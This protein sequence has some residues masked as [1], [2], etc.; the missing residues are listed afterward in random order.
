MKVGDI[1]Y[2]PKL[3]QY[4]FINEVNPAGKIVT[5]RSFNPSTGRLDLIEVID[6]IVEAVGLI[7]KLIV[8][9]KM[10]FAKKNPA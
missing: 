5:I 9:V 6:L 10:V 3:D 4:G 7:K 1:V 8:I 2:V